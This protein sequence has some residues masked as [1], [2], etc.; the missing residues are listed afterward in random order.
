[1]RLQKA[2]DKKIVSI[3][4]HEG[5]DRLVKTFFKKIEAKNLGKIINKKPI[6]AS[7]QEIAENPR[8]RS[9]KLRVLAV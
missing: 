2:I 3:A 4:F 1:M 5:E 6:Q 9:A 7:E 8:S